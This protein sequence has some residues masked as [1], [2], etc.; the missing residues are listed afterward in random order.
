MMIHYDGMQ[1]NTTV[2]ENKMA[3]PSNI[4]VGGS[5]VRVLLSLVNE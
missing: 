2:M 3:V 1:I 5:S 4:G